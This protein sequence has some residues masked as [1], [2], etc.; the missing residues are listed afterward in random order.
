MKNPDDSIAG[1]PEHPVDTALRV[2]APADQL[3][4]V[5]KEWDR[6]NP[7][8]ACWLI[9][10]RTNTALAV[11][12]HAVIITELANRG[13]TLAGDNSKAQGDL[14]GNQQS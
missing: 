11:L 5:K 9:L 3:A 8:A 2:T 10:S 4:A 13:Q 14:D 12:A 1:P 7:A 6:G